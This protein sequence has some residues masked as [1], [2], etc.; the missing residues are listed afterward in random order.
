[1]TLE[2][3]EK[4]YSKIV[5]LLDK[6]RVSKAL[7]NLLVLA[8]DQNDF[9]AINK[10]NEI[11]QTYHYLIHYLIIGTEDNSREEMLFK[12]ISDLRKIADSLLFTKKL[13]DS[14]LPYFSL[15]RID[16]LSPI[17]AAS[18]FNEIIRIDSEL[19][20]LIEIS[21][22]DIPKIFKKYDLLS[23]L[24][25]SIMASYHNSELIKEAVKT[26][27]NYPNLQD[28]ANTI[29]SALTLSLFQLYDHEKFLALVEIY[30]FT[31]NEN[32]HDSSK[33]ECIAARSLSAILLVAEMHPQKIAQ[34]KIVSERLAMW[35]DSILTYDRMR[36]VLMNILHTRDTDLIAR[37]MQEEIIPELMKLNPD[38]LKK[39]R[40][41]AIDFES[42]MLENNPEWSELLEK[43][44]LAKKMRELNEMQNEGADL[45]A[46]SF[47]NLKNFPFFNKI[48][49]WFI[50]FSEYH[51][52]LQ[53]S[54]D[55]RNIVATL[56]KMGA[57]IC[58]S[59]K[60]SLS[61]AL[62]KM[63]EDQRA[64]LINQLNAQISQIKESFDDLISD[65][66][67]AF[68][69]Y[70]NLFIRDLYRFFKNQKNSSGFYNPFSKL[71]RFEKIENLKNFLFN[72]QIINLV[73][74]YYFQRGFY[75]DSLIYFNLLIEEGVNEASL[76]EK[77]G[78]AYQSLNN[79]ESA[80]NAYKKA[81]LLR[82]PSKWLCR[83]LA[84]T[85]RKC[86]NLEEAYKYYSTLLQDAPE[87]INIISALGSILLELKRYEE[88]LKHFYHANYLEPDNIKIWRA[89]GWAELLITDHHEKSKKWLDKVIADSSLPTD[90]I[91]AGHAY[92]L[93]KDI[94]KAVSL[95]RRGYAQDS[96]VFEKAFESDRDDLIRLGIKAVD[97]DLICDS[98]DLK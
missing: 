74:E 80:L 66:G 45:M 31:L 51:P 49:N 90:L 38:E 83:K 54:K 2:T 24:F 25:N 71:F 18:I 1:M 12:L 65:V 63:P 15:A 91:N 7:A 3:T 37:K 10:I 60:Y 43:N 87:D 68:N 23:H 64:L 58:D 72:Q 59:D 86:G 17:N 29:I 88:A 61:I 93:S 47:G 28:I 79:F 92:L 62:S 50:P 44:G 52:E 53:L 78:F 41:V 96:K 77:I 16:R 56:F 95:Y 75:E 82:N 55:L 76:W 26:I 20:L 34:D 4:L 32:F 36:M 19:S 5:A 98:M 11:D 42:G 27:C 13:K 84:Y 8:E 35:Q 46:V 6:R 89:I 48:S 97:I 14:P 73:S 70:A 21:D 81:E 9:E 85:N 39:M 57:L 33:I 22:E 69:K 67:S 30:D 40:D 94:A